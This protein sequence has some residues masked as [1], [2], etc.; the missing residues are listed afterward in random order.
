[1][2][3]LPNP[4]EPLKDLK[5]LL[6]A[7]VVLWFV[8]FFGGGPENYAATPGPFLR[9]P[10]PTSTGEVH[11]QDIGIGLPTFFNKSGVRGYLASKPCESPLPAGLRCNM[12]RSMTLRF[13]SKNGKTIKDLVVKTDGRFSVD[14][15][16]GEYV[17]LQ[18]AY[19][20]DVAPFQHPQIVTVKTLRY[21]ETQVV[22]DNSIR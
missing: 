5:W 3:L 14:L 1:M 21:T 4:L 6:L 7:I 17:I 10:S 8:W 12:S 22:F 2:A 13:A 19:H 11:G 20:K 18:K 15:P 9:P 16:S